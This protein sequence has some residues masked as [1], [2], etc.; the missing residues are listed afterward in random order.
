MITKDFM[1]RFTSDDPLRPITQVI[2][3]TDGYYVATDTHHMLMVKEQDCQFAL[4]YDP[5]IHGKPLNVLAVIDPDHV[6]TTHCLTLADLKAYI[7][8]ISL[9]DEIEAVEV[10]T[11]FREFDCDKCHNGTISLSEWCHWGDNSFNV[12]EEVECPICHGFGKIPVDPEY[13]PDLCVCEDEVENW[14]TYEY[15]PTGRK[16]IG[17]GTLCRIGEMWF[18]ALYLP[19]VQQLMEQ[20][21]VD[22]LDFAFEREKVVFRHKSVTYVIASMCVNGNGDTNYTLLEEPLSIGKKE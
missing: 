14:K 21:G 9:E 22:S 11:E 2:F 5:A 12:E 20:L 18:R 3:P 19:Y 6:Q 1:Q 16:V 10:P 17:D 15:R 7:A 4:D 8:D 13:D